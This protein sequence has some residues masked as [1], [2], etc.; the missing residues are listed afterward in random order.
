VPSHLLDGLARRA[1]ELGQDVAM[2]ARLTPTCRGSCARRLAS[3]RPERGCCIAWPL[4]SSDFSAWSSERS[5]VC[6]QPVPGA[7]AERRLRAG[8][9]ARTGCAGGLEGALRLLVER[10]VYVTFDEVKGRR[11]AVRGAGERR[12]VRRTST[13]RWFGRTCSGT[14]AGAVADR[15]AWVFAGVR[16]GVGRR[17][18]RGVRSARYP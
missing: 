12:F 6:R 18:G 9:R 1:R 4:A 11:E 3:T 8:R 2:V 16:R 15:A 17:D 10:G 5:T 7:A 14:R 13:T